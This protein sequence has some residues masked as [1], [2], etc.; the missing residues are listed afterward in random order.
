VALAAGGLRLE[1]ACCRMSALFHETS[2]GQRFLATKDN[3]GDECIRK[4]SRVG[5][6]E[7]EKAR[8][9]SG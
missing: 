6:T 9:Q 2:Q 7:G 8:K 5:A 1:Q 3:D 4:Q